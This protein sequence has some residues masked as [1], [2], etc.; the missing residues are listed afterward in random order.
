MAGSQGADLLL[1][2]DGRQENYSNPVLFLSFP[3]KRIT[4][5]VE[6]F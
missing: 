1:L 6:M 5:G 4:V 3:S 2:T